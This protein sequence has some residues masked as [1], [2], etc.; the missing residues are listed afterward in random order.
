[1]ATTLKEPPMSDAKPPAAT[2]A[3]LTD[4]NDEGAKKRSRYEMDDNDGDDDCNDSP[5]LK[6]PRTAKDD[7]SSSEDESPPADTL[8]LQPQSMNAEDSAKFHEADN[9]RMKD[10]R[11][12]RSAH[13][14]MLKAKAEV[15][16]AQ[17]RYEEW[18]VSHSLCA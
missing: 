15:S 8:K 6:E 14:K 1:M 10:D 16:K 9:R 5:P 3:D 13:S 4:A 17:A 11:A 7:F 18:Y 2:A 12:V